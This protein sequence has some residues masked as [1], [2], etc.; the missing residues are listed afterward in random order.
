MKNKITI[1]VPVF[2]V[3]DY[4]DVCVESL[5]N[6][7][8]SNLEII[9]VDDGSD[10]RCPQMCDAWKEKDNRIVVIHQE[11]QGLSAA[12]NSALD[13]CSGDYIVFVDS[14]DWIHP[15]LCE[16]VLLQMEKKNAD[17]AIYKNCKTT[18]FVPYDTELIEF[19]DY[20]V[21][22]AFYRMYAKDQDYI[23]MVNNKMFKRDLIEH[24]HFE[25]GRLYE[26]AIIMP[27]ILDKNPKIIVSEQPLYY[28]R[29]RSTGIMGQKYTKKNLEQMVMY[30][31]ERILKYKDLEDRKLYTIMYAHY[32]Q[33][34]I[35][36]Y[37][38]L[39]EEEYYEEFKKMYKTCPV[40][41]SLKKRIKYALFY[42]CP[43]V[44]CILM[45]G[46]KL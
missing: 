5:V 45:K 26:D 16:H 44:I 27:E 15:R 23:N 39:H 29:L 10:D 31:R 17:L 30:H 9:L 7:S 20:S 1:I 13:I 37:S 32:F 12:R 36:V 40:S 6:Q 14:D 22:D 3:E 8:Y 11:N 18:E 42:I 34:L 38:R 21:K 25:C 4:L 33:N 2:R 35:F 28:Y 41:F 46:K 43:S 24:L 19:K